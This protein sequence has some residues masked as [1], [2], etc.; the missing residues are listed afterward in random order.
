MLSE[1]FLLNTRP[2][3]LT[4]CTFPSHDV[5]LKN[6]WRL[7]FDYLLQ[8]ASAATNGASFTFSSWNFFFGK[9]Q[10]RLCAWQIYSLLCVVAVTRFGFL[11]KRW[12]KLL[13]CFLVLSFL[14]IHFSLIDGI[15]IRNVIY[16]VFYIE[17]KGPNSPKLPLLLPPLLQKISFGRCL[18]RTK[19]RP[20]ARQTH[21]VCIFWY[22]SCR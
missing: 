13:E 18:I 6:K 8:P 19:S 22:D 15:L 1:V 12:Y 21:N 20:F 11:A 7:R 10:C 3:D 17:V 4:G 2:M 14:G 16:N 5:R 9:K